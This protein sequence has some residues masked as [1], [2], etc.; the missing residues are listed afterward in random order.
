MRLTRCGDAAM[1]S[2]RARLSPPPC[3]VTAVC[4]YVVRH[5]SAP[6]LTRCTIT[7]AQAAMIKSATTPVQPASPTGHMRSRSGYRRHRPR[8][9]VPRRQTRSRTAR[10]RIGCRQSWRSR[11]CASPALRSPRRWGMALSTVLGWR[12]R[13]SWMALSTVLGILKR[14]GWANSGAWGYMRRVCPRHVVILVTTV[15]RRWMQEHA[16]RQGVRQ[17][18]FDFNG[19]S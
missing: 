18:A 16:S 17:C 13:L 5:L 10:A 12:C 7:L 2:S 3:L 6:V 14:S 1:I 8:W 15:P 9:T 4:E 19:R 11:G